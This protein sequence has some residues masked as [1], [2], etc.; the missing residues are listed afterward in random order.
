MLRAGS[1][2]KEPKRVAPCLILREQAIPEKRPGKLIELV[3]LMD[4]F[5]AVREISLK[6]KDNAVDNA[7][8]YW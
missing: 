5:Y 6:L 7:E 1:R 3:S 8:V 4:G 2:R